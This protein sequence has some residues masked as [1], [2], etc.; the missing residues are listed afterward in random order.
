NFGRV[1]IA[2]QRLAGFN[3]SRPVGIVP[4]IECPKFVMFYLRST[5]AR[6]FMD[7]WANTTA[8]PT[9]NLKDVSNLPI[10]LPPKAVRRAIGHVL[11]TLDDMMELNRRMNEP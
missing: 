6:R 8:Q 7:N 3:T 11:G 1:A 9:F 10:P 2:P 4:I 5:F